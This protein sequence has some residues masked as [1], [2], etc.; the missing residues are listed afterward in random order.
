MCF[1]QHSPENTPAEI[2]TSQIVSQM[3]RWTDMQDDGQKDRQ[4]TKCVPWNKK[5]SLKMGML[6]DTC[7][8]NPQKTETC[9]SRVCC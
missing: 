9:D 8:P 6:T 3:D 1:M 7:I 2:D 4:G 5:L